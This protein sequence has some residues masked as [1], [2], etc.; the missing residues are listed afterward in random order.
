MLFSEELIQN[1]IIKLPYSQQTFHSSFLLTA[2][3]VL[4]RCLEPEKSH[5]EKHLC[6]K[7]LMT[8]ANALIQENLQQCHS[9]E[10]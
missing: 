5:K 10:Q 6:Y 4:I 3:A 2:V 1:Y 9:R 7:Q 8:N